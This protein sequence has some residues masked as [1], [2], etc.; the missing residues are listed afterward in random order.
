V[1]SNVPVIHGRTY[2]TRS[3]A[4]NRQGRLRNARAD[5]AAFVLRHCAYV[6]QFS[7]TIKHKAGALKRVAD[8]FSRKS[9]L[10]VTMQNEVLGFEF[11]KDLLLTDPFFG[12][13]VGDVAS[14]GRKNYGLFN[15]FLFK[16]HQLCIPDCSLRLKIIHERHNEG[17]MGRDKM[18]QLVAKQFY[19]PTMR[20]EVGRFVASCRVCQVSKQEATNAGL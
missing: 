2:S 14:E 1:R 3:T 15:G 12:L 4:E 17:H 7:F 20:V 19:W 13:I 8:A 6:Q 9:T 5:W 18:I 16:G 11:I 10:L